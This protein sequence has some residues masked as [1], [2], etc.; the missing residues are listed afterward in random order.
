MDRWEL[1]P[2]YRVTARDVTDVMSPIETNTKVYFCMARFGRTKPNGTNACPTRVT[3]PTLLEFLYSSIMNGCFF[4]YF[5][6]S[7]RQFV[8]KCKTGCEVKLTSSQSLYRN[9]HGFCGWWHLS[10]A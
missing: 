2:K 10:R 5:L 7:Q 4:T 3:V 6:L 9:T 8:K 1:V